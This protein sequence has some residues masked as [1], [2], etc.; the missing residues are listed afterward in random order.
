MTKTNFIVLRRWRELGEQPILWSKVD[1]KFNVYKEGRGIEFPFKTYREVRAM[2]VR[3]VDVSGLSASVHI[4]GWTEELVK[5]LAIPRLQSLEQLTLDFFFMRQ[6]FWEDCI[7]F[8]QL[9]SDFAPCVRKLT[10]REGSITVTPNP[11]PV[12]ELAQ[13][14][15]TKLIKFEEVDFSSPSFDEDVANYL[16]FDDPQVPRFGNGINSAIMRALPAASGREGSKLK[17]LTL[18]CHGVFFNHEDLAEARKKLRVNM[19]SRLWKEG[20]KSAKKG[21]GT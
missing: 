5:V 7:H 3:I 2:G 12:E 10:W 13:Q 16:S 6:I 19:V 4:C 11:T 9:V 18:D 20:G 1:L 14:L 17:S 8:L 15:K 21:G